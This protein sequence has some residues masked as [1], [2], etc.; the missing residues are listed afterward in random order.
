[1]EPVEELK[2]RRVVKRAVATETDQ[3]GLL[4][5]RGSPE[6]APVSRE[7]LNALLDLS[8][9]LFK[10]YD[11]IIEQE[12]PDAGFSPQRMNLFEID[13]TQRSQS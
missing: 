13:Q 2:L 1:V 6:P 12:S 5:K 8:G 4:A 3:W 7:A 10:R 9:R 11:L